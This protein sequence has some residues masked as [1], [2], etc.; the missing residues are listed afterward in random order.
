MK[1]GMRK[2]MALLILTVF[3]VSVVPAALAEDDATE[4]VDDRDDTGTVRDTELPL[5]EGETE[6]PT[7]EV[8]KNSRK[9]VRQENRREHRDN[10]QENMAERVANI[11]ET[12]ENVKE[13]L[14]NLREGVAERRAALHER[15]AQAKDTFH[16]HKAKVADRRDAAHAACQADKEAE[17]CRSARQ[18]LR[19]SA[20]DHLVKTGDV[21]I[22]SLEKTAERLEASDHENAADSLVVVNDAIIAIQATVDEISAMDHDT[23]EA[24]TVK[25][26]I[27]ELKELAKDAKKVN[28]GAVARLTHEKLGQVVEKQA[29]FADSMQNKLTEL[30][31]AG[32]D[33]TTLDVIYGEFL[34]NKDEVDAAYRTAQA[35]FDA[36]HAGEATAKEWQA[37]FQVAREELKESKKILR[38]F[39][40]EYRTL[41]KA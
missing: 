2:L 30:E 9:E 10:R 20:L 31:T 40:E 12:G 7:T 22:A 16:A 11:R 8:E 5:A 18:G 27:A 35:T 14:G 15:H 24:Q 41:T 13:R 36:F 23:V 38:S 3:V 37:D 4:I 6:L 21:L 28:R 39:V 29:L 19:G 33:V 25:D 17:D 32:Y 34:N 26:A 1:N